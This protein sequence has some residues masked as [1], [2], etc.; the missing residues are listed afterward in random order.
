MNDILS[1]IQTLGLIP[2]VKLED[3]EQAVPLAQALRA[4]GLPCAEITF[5]A[6]GADKAIAAITK[7]FPDML[8][9]AGTVLTTEQAERAIASGASFIVSPGINPKIVRFCRDKGVLVLP[10][11][12]TPSD[13]ELAIEEGL[14]VVKFFPAEAAGGIAMIKAMA[15]PY[16][17]VRFMPT[18]GINPSNIRE[19]LALDKVVACGGSWMVP[20]ELIEAG[21]FDGITTLTKRALR[22][23]Y[24]FE[25]AH[26]GV[27]TDDESAAAQAAGTFCSLFGFEQRDGG[28]SYFAGNEIEVMKLQFK[29]AHGHLALRTHLIERAVAY[30]ES[31]GVTFDYVG[32]GRD[33][34]GKLT[35]I[36]LTEQIGGFAVHLV[37]A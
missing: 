26:V 20:A 7:A 5:R 9:G 21:D 28:K 14:S 34:S 3:P 15:A 8:I 35:L 31:R 17:N 24:G 27:N 2:V 19:Y 37:K 18:G 25:L 13:V 1:R 36:Y 4:G 23:M 30:L 29:G 11:C 22:S 10:G 16:V 6:P 33:A 12:A 32:A